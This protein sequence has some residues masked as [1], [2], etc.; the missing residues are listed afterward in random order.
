[1]SYLIKIAYD[2]SKFYGFQ[3]LNEEVTVQKTLEEALSKINKSDVVVKGAG[4]TDRGVHANC[5]CVSFNLDINIDCEGLKDALNSLVK[6]YIYVK[7]VQEVKEDF[8]ARFSVTK[9]RYVYKINLGEYN[10]IMQ[11]YVYQSP[12]ELDLDLMRE[13]SKLYLGAHDFRNFVS[14]ERD[15][16]DCIIYDIDF[17]IKNDILMITFEG[18]S[19]YRYMIRNLVGAMIEVARGK[20][21]LDYV[22]EMLESKE[23]KT[24]F[25]APANGLYLDFIDYN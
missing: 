25:T 20:I 6:P 15:N 14:G 21:S 13:V 22:K 7:E 5:Q 16:Y 23:E 8:H 17:E 11:D 3:R 10:P 9:K 2:G 1:M 12:Y 19:F 24:T 18:K 4:R